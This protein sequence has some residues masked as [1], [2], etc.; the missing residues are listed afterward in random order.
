MHMPDN[1]AQK[2]KVRSIEFGDSTFRKLRGFSVDFSDR[3]TLIA[4]HNGIGKST[5]LG[6]VANTFGLADSGD[7][8]SYFGEQF[9]A[10]VEKIVYLSLSEVE[11]QRS[12]GPVVT[13]EVGAE[14]VRK[15]CAMTRRSE[16]KRARVVPRL[17]GSDPTGSVSQDGKFRLPTIYL[18]MRRLA[19]VGEADEG[20]VT[21]RRIFMD[22]ADEQ[23]MFDFVTQVIHGISLTNETTRQSIKGSKKRTVQPGYEGY[24][25]LAVSVGQDSLASIATALASFNRLSREQ[26]A[27]YPGGLLVVDE[28]DAGFHPHAIDRLIGALKS[29]ARRL[30]LQIIAT[31]HSPRL[32][33]TLHPDGGGH[34]QADDSVVYLVDTRRPRP[35]EDQSLG[36]ILDDM[37]MRIVGNEADKPILFAHFEDEEAFQFFEAL[38]P[39]AK[40]RG[41]SRRLGIQMM[42]YPMGIGG[43]QLVALP[44]KDPIFRN[45]LLVVDGD[46][47]IPAAATASGNIVKL[48]RPKGAAGTDRSPE[49]II[50]L[51]LLETTK[52]TNGPIYEAMLK[53]RT[54]NPTTDKVSVTF[55]DGGVGKSGEREKA[56]AWWI[57]HWKLIKQWG[58]VERWA[59]LH[60]QEVNV[61]LKSLETAITNIAARINPPSRTSGSL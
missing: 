9:Y 52:A 2:I 60:P 15:R 51:F 31:T 44:Q 29:Y 43:S 1:Q 50:R 14:K 12:E 19:P 3:I 18:G 56:K 37:A 48:P 25:S 21:S 33:E 24:E 7:P 17:V 30:H 13:A 39:G 5:I 34:V 38:F 47:K 28:L 6:L 41:L 58:V 10:N 49:N 53:F 27:D 54:R 40:R 36:A 23:L 22:T 32:I 8:Q 26:G 46:T 35:A 59:E 45:R 4:G 20:D 55:F 16:W 57:T 11:G 61:F 42:L